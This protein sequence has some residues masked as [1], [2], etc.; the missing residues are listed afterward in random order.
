M[1]TQLTLI[2][3][4]HSYAELQSVTIFRAIIVDDAVR[5]TKPVEVLSGAI[6]VSD[7]WEGFDRLAQESR[8]LHTPF[9]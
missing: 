2:S 9:K 3:I 1:H 6:M 4:I 8:L 5:P 7:Y